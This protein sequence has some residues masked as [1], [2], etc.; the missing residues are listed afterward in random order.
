V[1]LPLGLNLAAYLGEVFGCSLVDRRELPLRKLV[2]RQIVGL[3]NFLD[4]DRFDC[5]GW[6]VVPR[7]PAL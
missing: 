1:R 4:I 5:L 7:A 2:G 3:D 6:V